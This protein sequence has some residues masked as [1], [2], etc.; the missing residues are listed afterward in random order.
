MRE[1]DSLLAKEHRQRLGGGGQGEVYALDQAPD[2][3][4]KS[5]KSGGERANWAALEQL[6]DTRVALDGDDADWVQPRTV[7][8][9]T[10]VHGGGGDL[11][12]LLMPRIPDDYFHLYGIRSAPKLVPREWN[13]LSMRQSYLSNPNLEIGTLHLVETHQLI[14]LVADLA[15]TIDVLHRNDIVVGDISG[16]NLLWRLEPAPQ[17]MIIDCDSFRLC[18]APAVFQP[19]QTPDWDDPY[20]AS[21]ETDQSSDIYKLGLAAFRAVWS[22]GTDRPPQGLVGLP[23]PDGSPPPRPL[24][25]L[26]TQSCG[27]TNRPSA[28]D[29]VA[30]LKTMIMFGGRPSVPMRPVTQRRLP[31]VPQPAQRARP[32][33]RIRKDH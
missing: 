20:L 23:L 3:V 15:G 13:Y 19:K 22:A 32:V 25:D 27:P 31:S 14:A 7:W 11:V 26:I 1:S 33:L 9:H 18:R 2:V 5:F 21:D 12:G 8:P 30:I 29:W 4:Y 16:R 17:T 10:S 28:A 24:V 6:I